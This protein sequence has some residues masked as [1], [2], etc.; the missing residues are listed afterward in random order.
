MKKRLLLLSLC[1]LSLNMAQGQRKIKK[2][3]VK[4]EG[5]NIKMSFEPVV[6]NLTYNG[7]N[8]KITPVSANELN[9][10]FLKENYFTGKFEYSYYEKSRESYFL[11]KKRGKRKKSDLE[12]YLEGIAWLFDNDLI[13]E[14]EHDELEKNILFYYDEDFATGYYDGNKIT[15]ANP[16]FINERYLNLFKVVISNPT[17]S[18]I[19]LDKNLMVENGA[20]LLDHLTSDN[21]FKHLDSIDRSNSYKTM[22][23]ER[24]NFK[25][26]MAIPPNSKVEKYLAVLPINFN[27]PVLNI[28]LEGVPKKL[29]W[30]IIKDEKTINE[31]YTFYELELKWNND[32][33]VQ[34]SL[35]RGNANSIFMDENK[36]F[37]GDESL[38]NSFELFTIML[39]RNSLHYGRHVDLKGA[40]FVD[41]VKLKRKTIKTDVKKIEELKKKVKE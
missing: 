41:K 25:G 14:S 27:H 37:I 33:D 5:F 8:V 12:F 38:N 11:R 16:Y 29:S 24:H 18:H 7:L 22:T 21:L 9:D 6:D 36:L 40:D 26:S 2:V 34:F 31:L 13:N 4:E 35:L 39:D 17:A 10:Q 23:L 1:L 20:I 15:A 32:Y 28:S 30:N 3:E 19:K